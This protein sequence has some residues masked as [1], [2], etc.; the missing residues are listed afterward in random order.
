[1]H[2]TPKNKSK[3]WTDA[4]ILKWYS[5]APAGAEEWFLGFLPWGLELKKNDIFQFF[6]K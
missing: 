1:M 5:S 4:I 6:T 2:E 3:K